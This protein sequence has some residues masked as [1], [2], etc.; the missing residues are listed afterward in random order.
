MCI[1]DRKISEGKCIDRLSPKGASE[2]DEDTTLGP[3]SSVEEEVRA[4]DAERVVAPSP[5]PADESEATN[6]QSGPSGGLCTLHGGA[7]A[8]DVPAADDAGY[9]AE[10]LLPRGGA[11]SQST[12]DAPLAYSSISVSTQPGNDEQAEQS[13]AAELNAKDSGDATNSAAVV[14]SGRDVTLNSLSCVAALVGALS[15][16]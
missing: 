7:C 3:S 10:T 6:F 5:A 1:R 9:E 14:S 2:D 12:A 15:L 8:E 4:D 13:D 11:A 16:L